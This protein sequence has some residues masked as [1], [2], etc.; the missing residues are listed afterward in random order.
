MRPLWNSRAI[1]RSILLPLPILPPLCV[2]R[3]SLSFSLKWRWYWHYSGSALHPHTLNDTRNNRNA[4]RSVLQ[5]QIHTHTHTHFWILLF[6][7][8]MNG[9]PQWDLSFVHLWSACRID[10]WTKMVQVNSGW[11]RPFA[12]WLWLHFGK[13]YGVMC[14]CVCVLGQVTAIRSTVAQTIPKHLQF[15]YVYSTFDSNSH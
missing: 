15:K 13:W 14:V 5:I 11:H 7:I 12:E 3:F 10:N 1:L 6:T 4:I 2:F 9:W 8:A